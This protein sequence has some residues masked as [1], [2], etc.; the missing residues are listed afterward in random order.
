MKKAL[1]IILTVL[2]L[3]QG[4]S[5]LAAPMDYPKFTNAKDAYDLIYSNF[6]QGQD[7]TIFYYGYSNNAN[8]MFVVNDI[9]SCLAVSPDLRLNTLLGMDAILH[10]WRERLITVK[11]VKRELQF[12]GEEGTAYNRE[13][14]QLAKQIIEKTITPS[15]TEEQKHRALYDWLIDNVKYD[16]GTPYNPDASFEENFARGYDALN[17]LRDRKAVCSGYTSAYTLLCEL[18]GLQVIDVHSPTHALNLITVNGDWYF[19]DATWGVTTDPSTPL[20]PDRRYKY[21]MAKEEILD[22]GYVEHHVSA[23]NFWFHNSGTGGY[24]DSHAYVRKEHLDA[25]YGSKPALQPLSNANPPV[26]Y[27]PPVGDE[28]YSS[29]ANVFFNQVNFIPTGESAG[30]NM[31]APM[32]RLAFCESLWMGL[33]EAGVKFA[34]PDSDTFVDTADFFVHI[35]AK[36]GIV[37]GVGNSKFNPYGE[38]TREQAATM[39]ANAARYMGYDTSGFSPSEYADSSEISSW[40]KDSIGFINAKGIM[41]GVGSNKFSPKGVYTVEQSLITIIRLCD[42]PVLENAKQAKPTTWQEAMKFDMLRYM[43]CLDNEE[44]PIRAERV[45]YV[46]WDEYLNA[47][48]LALTDAIFYDDD[49]YK[50]ITVGEPLFYTHGVVPPDNE[51]NAFIEKSAGYLRETY[52]KQIEKSR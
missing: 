17:A 13:V 22:A 3:A 7:T 23:Y 52:E 20:S 27:Q 8:A 5:V 25:V 36:A 47:Y 38:I 15:M 19:V 1:A 33:D 40:A 34:E 4:L 43:G 31:Q 45:L 41:T 42:L 37:S 35:L 39:L 44:I 24:R 48:R 14:V 9:I 11:V 30:T 26:K 49:Y 46:T 16:Y 50:A 12:V 6:M 10:D 51:I 32:T 29:W 2:I 18:A 28:E 21:F